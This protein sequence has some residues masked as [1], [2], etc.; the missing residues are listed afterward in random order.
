[1]SGM[2]KEEQ[3]IKEVME[4]TGWSR[5]KAIDQME[6]AKI[7]VG[8]SY[9]DY[10][11]CN[12]HQFTEE[13]QEEAYRK[14]LERRELRR[15]RKEHCIAF[16]ME[17]TGWSYEEADAKIKDARKRLGL[18]YKEYEKYK[19]FQVPV[20]EQ[21]EVYDRKVRRALEKKK[22]KEDQERCL[23]AVMKITGWTEEYTRETL[24]RAMEEVGSSYEHYLIYRFWELTEEEQKTYFKKLMKNKDLFYEH[25]HK[26][27]GRDWMKKKGMTLEEFKKKFA[28]EEKIMYKPLDASGGYGIEV[29]FL[30]DTAIEEV[31][32][33]L[34][35]L[36][37]G[38]VEQYLL[39]HSE[40]QK[41]SLNSVNTIRIV[42]VR[43]GEEI[44]GVENGKVN[45][46]Y[47]GVRMG[48]GESYVD[49]L[50]S[51][52]MMAILDLETG[53]VI[54]NGA[55]HENHVYEVHPDTGTVIKGF[56]I[57]FFKEAKEL[58]AVAG[59]DIDGFLGWDV[60]I[61]E[62]GPVLIEANGSPGADGLQIP[63]V[64]E[65]KGVRYMIEKYL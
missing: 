52:G 51:G 40:M 9:K 43:T 5:G 12:F 54:T 19:L 35:S 21:Q 56:T 11:K 37:D 44:E 48:Q 65:R 18:T 42:T 49:N 16:T 59:K 7:K 15:Q 47:A 25:F 61:T 39:Q 53:K 57:P 24:D 33:K 17:K 6:S 64:P 50:H 8:I 27:L 41:L 20:E 14:I 32:K 46:V 55:N 62:N 1:M 38:I 30:K 60:A 31:Y 10:N 45:F 13:D 36:P 3:Y 58:I 28:N 26:Y 4:K 22:E 23:Q 63:F 34:I 29:F 2:K